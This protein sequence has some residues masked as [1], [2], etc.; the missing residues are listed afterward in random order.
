MD[1]LPLFAFWSQHPYYELTAGLSTLLF[2][3]SSQELNRAV[4]EE[5]ISRKGKAYRDFIE[6]AGLFTALAAGLT[7]GI[8]PFYLSLA[9]LVT[10]GVTKI[11][12][13]ELTKRFRRSF[14]F[15][16]GEK[17]WI[18]LTGLIYLTTYSNSYFLF[19]GYLLL[20]AVILYDLAGLFIELKERNRV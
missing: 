11:Y 3:F 5:S 8:V 14:N 19:Y 16:L 7:A 2:L 1:L 10:L 4:L 15:S 17:V 12:E 13:M 6:T 20:T 18:G 9:L